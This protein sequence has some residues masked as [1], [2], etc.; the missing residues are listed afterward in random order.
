VTRPTG[1]SNPDGRRPLTV[2]VEPDPDGHRF[3]WVSHVVRALEREGSDVMLL[4]ST[5]ATARAEFKAFLADLPVTAVERFDQVYP[6]PRAVGEALLEVHRER[7]IDRFVIMDSDQLLKRWWLVAPRQLRHRRGGPFGVVLMTRFPPSIPLDRHLLWLRS[8]KSLLAVLA[9]LRGSAQRVAYVA[10]RD[11]L[12]Q[13]L[14]FKRLRDPA[15]C[16]AHASQR[17]ELREEAGLPQDRRLIGILGKVDVRKNVPLVGRAVFAAG[18]EVDLL[19]A[20][21]LSE[22]VQ[23]WLD[24][25]PPAERARVHVRGGFLPESEID[26]LTACC[27]VV[28]IVHLNPG[29]SGIMGKAQVAGVP[30]LSGGSRVRRRETVALGSGIH[31][32]AT[33]EGLAEGLRVL[34]ARGP[35]PVPPPPSLPTAEEFGDVVLNGGARAL[36]RIR[37][38]R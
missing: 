9:M 17:A 21:G 32:E 34:L 36:T 22:D 4:T 35:D 30:V 13:G 12:R 7:S 3:Q 16:R 19:L 27:D 38:A 5:G 14:L 20:G 37:G 26:A 33:V 1:D 24:A 31:T 29:P 25:L 23:E 28:A 2:L 11:Q 15:L 18:P 10:G 8:T 6:P